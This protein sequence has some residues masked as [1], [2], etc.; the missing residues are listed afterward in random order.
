V[1]DRQLEIEKT[2]LDLH[3]R[4]LDN[5]Q[6]LDWQRVDYEHTHNEIELERITQGKN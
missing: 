5:V 4:Q 3:M 6:P 1:R 2:Y